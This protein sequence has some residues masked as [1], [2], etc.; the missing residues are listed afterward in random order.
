MLT[1]TLS[2]L[3][4]DTDQ[5]TLIQS[6]KSKKEENII[7][8]K[9]RIIDTVFISYACNVVKSEQPNQVFWFATITS[10]CI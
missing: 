10:S 4:P 8:M 9:D 2:F 7:K 3:F 1:K 5:P 6:M